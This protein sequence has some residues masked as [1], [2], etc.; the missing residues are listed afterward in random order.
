MHLR[1]GQK[2][3]SNNPSQEGNKRERKQSSLTH[4]GNKGVTSSKTT[5]KGNKEE[6]LE[7]SQPSLRC[8]P[9]QVLPTCIER[10]EAPAQENSSRKHSQ[11]SKAITGPTERKHKQRTRTNKHTQ[12]KREEQ[13]AQQED[14]P[15]RTPTRQRQHQNQSRE[16]KRQL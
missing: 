1:F 5:K 10:Q 3:T 9:T 14:S 11:K 16:V 13:L 4:S 8:K 7:T 2:A 6:S 15:G 12:H